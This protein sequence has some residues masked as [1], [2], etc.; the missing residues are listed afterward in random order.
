MTLKDLKD[1]RLLGLSQFLLDT[2]WGL[3]GIC[4]LLSCLQDHC[5]SLYFR[6][7]MAGKLI[8]WIKHKA[9]EIRR[10]PEVLVFLY[11]SHARFV[12]TNEQYCKNKCN[13]KGNKL[14]EAAPSK[15]INRTPPERTNCWVLSSCLKNT[16][17]EKLYCLVDSLLDGNQKSVGYALLTSKILCKP[18][19]FLVIQILF[20]IK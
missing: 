16:H 10:L 3:E 9:G 12:R 7:S 5:T 13:V 2:S 6:N 14:P 1:V 20:W 15:L 19:Y 17:F 4:A 18:F 8:D 11:P